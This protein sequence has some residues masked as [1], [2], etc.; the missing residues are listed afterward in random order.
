MA[1]LRMIASAGAEGVR[2]SGVASGLGLHKASTSRVLNTLVALDILERGDDRRF[3]VAASFQQMLGLPVSM[4]RLRQA[5]RPALSQIVDVLGDSAFLSVRGG[6]DA[7]CIDRQVGAHPL[8]AL[9]LD[10]GSR[11]PLGVGAGSLALL[12]WLPADECEEMIEA[13]E[14]RLERY[15]N[16]TPARLHELVEIARAEG[17]TDLPNFVIPGMTGMGIPIRDVTGLVVGAVSV[18][19]VGD[20]LSG[21]RRDLAA[22]LLHEASR[23][24]E[25]RLAGSMVEGRD[26][27]A[28]TITKTVV[29]TARQTRNRR[30]TA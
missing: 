12:A 10:V 2:L 18:A 22:G 14:G 29:N 15:P 6:F 4:A 28:T 5:A 30:K 9:S 1:I 3:R 7:V 21:G 17:F 8:Q 24:T 20:R 11:R 25:E 13:Q 23:T 19:A 16:A 27:P 26:L